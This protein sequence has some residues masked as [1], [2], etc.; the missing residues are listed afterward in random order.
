MNFG[1][2]CLAFIVNHCP[3]LTYL[4]ISKANV[5]NQSFK[6]IRKLTKLK[7]INL[8][9][10]SKISDLSL[11]KLF[12]QC[13]QLESV[14]MTFCHTVVGKCFVNDGYNLKSIKM[15]QCGSVNMNLIF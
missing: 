13:K 8:S 4:N 15:D 5:S 3:N 10:C 12:K 11:S 9:Y 2:L 6:H 14:D 7:D 1:S